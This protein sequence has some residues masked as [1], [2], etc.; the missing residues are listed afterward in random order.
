MRLE[1]TVCPMPT[2]TSGRSIDIE[3]LAEYT[4][5]LVNNGVHGL[6]PCGSIGEFSSLTR[7]QRRHVLEAVA[8]RSGDVPVLAGCGNTNTAD[9]AN[10]I[11]DAANAGAD[12]AVVVTPYYLST[13]Q[14]GLQRFFDAVADD[15]PLPIVLYNIPALTG[16]GLPLELVKQFAD[17]PNVVGLKD[18][19]GDLTFLYDVVEA[20][21]SSFT[22][23]QGATELS[24]ASLDAGADGMIAGPANVFPGAVARLYESY[25][26]G[27]RE[28]TNQL[29]NE[30]VNPVVSATSEPPTAAAIKHLVTRQ[31]YD[32][33]EPLPPLPRLSDN[34][35]E[36]LDRC[37]ESVQTSLSV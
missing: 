28:R 16:E 8:D 23:F 31:G 15:S 3:T 34:Q 29:M 36:M 9:V 30:V 11:E 21:P 20:T 37:F 25:R 32:V 10:H 26:N 12:T 7:V 1:G 33:G 24:V 22:V 27:N 14:Q 19:S 18:T 17:H 2:P 6:F 35:R 4:D 5:Y 13:T